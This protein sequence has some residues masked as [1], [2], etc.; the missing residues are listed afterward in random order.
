VR[1]S[2]FREF[3]ARRVMAAHG[4]R[5]GA[6]NRSKVTVMNSNQS[7]GSLRARGAHI[8]TQ[9]GLLILLVWILILL[10]M[11]HANQID[12]AET[13][14]ESLVLTSVIAE[15]VSRSIRAIDNTLS[16]V[17]ED[18][19]QPRESNRLQRLVESGGVRMD[20]LVLLSF[21]DGDGHL[22]QTNRGP[23]NPPID[24]TDREHIRVHLDGKVKGLF[25]GKPVRGRAS[26]Q[27]S[28]QLTRAV[29]GSDG[30]P[31]GVIVGSLD[32]LYFEGFWRDSSLPRGMRIEVLGVDGALRAHA[33]PLSSG[34]IVC[35]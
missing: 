11:R 23:S 12:F 13:E 10:T 7:R 3:G 4:M 1:S 16:F 17:A 19:T 21:V 35:D 25:V 26:G 28:I 18:F 24:L 9:A 2:S 27:W 33:Y 31:L 30:I 22:R 20:N 32:P 14:R 34:A 5:I 15:Q 29:I 6:S 8:V